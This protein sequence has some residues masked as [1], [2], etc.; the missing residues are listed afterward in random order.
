MCEAIAIVVE[1]SNEKRCLVAPRPLRKQKRMPGLVMKL[2]MLCSV[3]HLLDLPEICRVAFRD[4][5]KVIGQ[6]LIVG[7]ELRFLPTVGT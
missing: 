5:I 1:T 3:E 2:I 7:A 6:V 4:V